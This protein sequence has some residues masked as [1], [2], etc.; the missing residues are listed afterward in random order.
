MNTNK[1]MMLLALGLI[2]GCGS[3]T[4]H[5]DTGAPMDMAV[6]QFP[7]APTLGTTMLD[8]MGRAGVNTALTD[9]FWTSKSDHEAKLDAYNH[10]QPAQWGGFAAQFA[11]ALAVL[12]GLDG[13]CGNQPL[14]SAGVDGGASVG[15]GALAGILT[16]D[17]LLLDTAVS[18]CDPKQNYLAVEVAVITGAAKPASCGGRTPL[19]PAI[20]VTYAVLSGAI[21]GSVTVTDGVSGDGDPATNTATLSA[22]PYLGMP[23]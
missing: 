12:D 5:P 15:Y 22:F 4:M 3:S 18:T 19:D 23:Q 1:T 10:A 21:G 20:D 7:T 2:A 6:A 14:F 11:G 8:R 16:N 13:M 17:Q 9:P